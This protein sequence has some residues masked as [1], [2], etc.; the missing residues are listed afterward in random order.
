M[1]TKITVNNNGSLR[2]EGEFEIYDAGG[3]PYD[4]SG[5]TVIG[6]CRC[7]QSANK[8]FCDGA[9]ARCGFQ[10]QVVAT[11]LPPPKPKA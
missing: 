9:H 7:G 11:V 10:S 1:A 2:I 3:N 6:L 4:L 5:R 8:P